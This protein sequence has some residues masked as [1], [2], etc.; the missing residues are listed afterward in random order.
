VHWQWLTLWSADNLHVEG[1]DDSKRI[2]EPLVVI[3]VYQIV[4]VKP[5]QLFFKIQR[6]RA[7]PE[8]TIEPTLPKTALEISSLSWPMNWWAISNQFISGLQYLS[9]RSSSDGIHPYTESRLS[10]HPACPP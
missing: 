1:L 4:L 3:H 10:Y 9:D 8:M 7:D 5:V 2:L 6:L